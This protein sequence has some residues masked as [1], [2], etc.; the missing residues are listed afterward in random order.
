MTFHH[1]FRVTLPSVLELET[2]L[3]TEDKLASFKDNLV[4]PLLFDG[5]PTSLIP[6]DMDLNYECL[7][8]SACYMDS[9]PEVL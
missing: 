1:I 7:D 5:E 4:S 8:D 6:S 2:L 3:Y 9:E